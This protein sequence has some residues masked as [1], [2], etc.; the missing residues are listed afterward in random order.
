MLGGG[1]SL[2]HGLQELPT[3]ALGPPSTST[4]CSCTQAF[5]WSPSVLGW[6]AAPQYCSIRCSSKKCLTNKILLLGCNSCI[7]ES[8]RDIQALLNYVLNLIVTIVQPQKKIFLT[9]REAWDDS[10]GN[11]S[12]VKVFCF[13]LQ[14]PSQAAT[15]KLKAKGPVVSLGRVA[16]I[17]GH[18][19]V[20]LLC[21]VFLYHQLY[22]S[23]SIQRY[24]L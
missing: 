10:K 7:S 9:L 3:L 22:L 8:L 20:Y 13:N 5:H 6:A 11:Q 12:H 16:R 18:W 21:F 4:M 19:V 23:L 1:P 2:H 24:F 15:P 17:C 14:I